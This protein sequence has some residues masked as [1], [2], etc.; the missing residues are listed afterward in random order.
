MLDDTIITSWNAL[1]ISALARA[2]AAF[3]DSRYLAAAGDAARFLDL[4]KL[5]QRD[6][7]IVL[8]KLSVL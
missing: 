8:A 4:K 1:I 6:K 2:G 5:S 3:D 7:Q